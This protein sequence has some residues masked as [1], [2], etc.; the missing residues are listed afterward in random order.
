MTSASPIDANANQNISLNLIEEFFNL[1]DEENNIVNNLKDE[2]TDL[3]FFNYGSII[4]LQSNN[5]LTNF[6]HI[7]ELLENYERIY[8]KSCYEDFL[9]LRQTKCKSFF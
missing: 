2:F 5:D 9:V 6:P 3:S 4:Y 8:S 1:S 7:S